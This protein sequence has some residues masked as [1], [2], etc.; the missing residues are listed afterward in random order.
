VA[1]YI[2]ALLFGGLLI[3]AS[4][5]GAGDH[6]VDVHGAGSADPHAGGHGNALLAA[7]L[8]VRFW[9]FAA[10]FFG[11]TGL[12]LRVVGGTAL[13]ASAPLVG[14][15]VGAAAGFG[16]SWF[17]RKMTRESV[18][19]VV[20]AGALVGREGRLLLPVAHPQQGK[21]R[22]AQPAGGHLDLVAEAGAGEA[23]VA[24]DEVIIVEVRG[25]VAVV[26]RAPATRNS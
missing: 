13:R 11:V 10:A 16:A 7:I 12:V 3:L 25:N 15:V 6:P 19:R 5:V 22:L 21:V 24:G 8:G 14:A 9:S 20:D 1:I 26:T 23:L 2:G 17:F 18:G 4:L